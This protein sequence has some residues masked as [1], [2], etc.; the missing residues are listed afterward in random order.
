MP[1]NYYN[2]NKNLRRETEQLC[3]LYGLRPSHRHSQNFLIEP[4]F[5]QKLVEVADIQPTDEILEI[6]PGWGFL[7]MALAQR[8]KKV[9]AV[10]LDQRLAEILPTR[11]LAGGF[12]NI[13]LIHHDILSVVI[14]RPELDAKPGL[15]NITLPTSYKL[16]ANLPYSITSLCLKRFLSGEVERPSLMVIMV[17]KEVALRLTA[18]PGKMSLLSLLGQYYS[19]PTYIAEVPATN[20]W[21]KPQVDS[22]IVSLRL[23]QPA[24]SGEDERWLWR[25]ARIG[26]SSRR[27]MLKNNLSAGL[28]IKESVVVN[29][30]TKVQQNAQCRAQDLSIDQWLGLVGIFKDIMI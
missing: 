24:L 12:N 25:L 11:F 5:Y 18:K 14:N 20:F 4:G 29:S 3:Q 15:I 8:A 22:A 26:F 21:P 2:L 9:T 10:E 17:Q 1:Q 6:G 28:K 13:T 23:I 27:K 16:V 7:S 30:L 19:Q